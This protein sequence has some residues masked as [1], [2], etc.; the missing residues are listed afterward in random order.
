MISRFE[1]E[2]SL[3][4]L[5]K[6]PVGQGSTRTPASQKSVCLSRFFLCVTRNRRTK[7]EGNGKEEY[8]CIYISA[9]AHHFSNVAPVFCCALNSPFGSNVNVNASSRLSARHLFRPSKRS[10]FLSAL[11]SL[12]STDPIQESGGGERDEE[13]HVSAAAI[14]FGVFFFL[15][16]PPI[17]IS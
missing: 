13:K 9:H 16:T 11:A 15:S 7:D 17:W 1:N 2:I 10:L 12:L 6:G 4:C 14:R 8:I 3:W 5:D